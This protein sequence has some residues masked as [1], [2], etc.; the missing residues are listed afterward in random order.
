MGPRLREIFALPCLAHDLANQYHLLGHLYQA[1]LILPDIHAVI[2][3]MNIP[4]PILT[5]PFN[6]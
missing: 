3:S 1:I 2:P 4:L 6:T 5:I